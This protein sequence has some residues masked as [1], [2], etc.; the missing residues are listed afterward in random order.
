MALHINDVP[1]APRRDGTV[2]W[3]SA[4][5]NFSIQYNFSAIAIALAFMD[6]GNDADP[7][8]AFPRTPAESSALKSLVFAGAITGQFTMGMAGDRFGR[9]KAML[10]TNSFAFIGAL[11]SALLTLGDA[12]AVY[13][14]M[15]VCRFL[16]GVGVGGKYPLAATMSHEDAQSNASVD[17]AKAFF[18][19]SEQ[20]TPAPALHRDPS[21][22]RARPR[23]P[24]PPRTLP[25]CAPPQRSLAMLREIRMWLRH[26]PVLSPCSPRAL[27][28]I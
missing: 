24:S 25:T 23:T 6:N 10:L 20:R 5:S 19:Q 27:L 22:W 16:L 17:T 12:R 28:V 26:R 9:R 14:T 21:Q 8:P 1:S 7:D 3:I 15:S 18:W 2:A 11:G 4:L 13:T